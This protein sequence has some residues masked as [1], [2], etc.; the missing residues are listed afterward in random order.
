MPIEQLTKLGRTRRIVRWGAAVL[1]TRAT[2]VV[3]FGADLQRLL[4]DLFATNAA[5]HGAGL[6]APQIGIS[7]AAFVYD[8]FDDD[9]HRRVGVMCNPTLEL[10]A[11]KDRSLDSWE[12]GC[13]SLPGGYAEL[14]RAGRV[15]CRGQDQ[16]GE[17]IAVLGTGQ[18]ARCLQH[19]TDHLA[20][21]VF[22]D[23]LSNRA[24][25][26][27]YRTHHLVA[28]LYPPDWPATSRTDDVR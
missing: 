20:G 2:P 14:A 13:L 8:C 16:Y 7:V 11:G 27:L 12:E 4:A 19:E 21:I 23:R 15:V 18:L 9:R 3:D 24:R 10:P 6:A 22:G 5:A 28:D 26:G 25:R 1:H 17:D